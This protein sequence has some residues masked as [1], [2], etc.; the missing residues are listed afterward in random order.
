MNKF[1][2]LI[3]AHG[4]SVSQIENLLHAIFRQDL[5]S[6][7]LNKIFLCSDQTTH[8]NNFKHRCS[9]TTIK[10]E[11]NLGK[12]NALNM[13]LRQANSDIC[14]QNS[15]DCIPSSNWTY[16][17]LL[18]PFLNNPLVGAV[19]CKPEPCDVGFMFLPNIVWKC[20]NYVQPKLCG[21]LFSFKKKLISEL[22]ESVVHDDAYIHHILNAQGYRVVYASEAIVYNSMPKLFSEFYM[23]RKKNVVGNMQLGATFKV[24]PP[25]N[26]RLRSL[27]LMGLEL[28]ANVHGR[29]DYVRGKIPVGLVGYNLKS[30]KE[31]DTNE[32]VVVNSPN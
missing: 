10:Q 28:L 16:H 27:I 23:Q 5:E 26:L 20:H 31:V 17:F 14:V 2:V 13:M 9:I 24:N 25:R 22:P 6:F 3:P 15:A 21:E 12:P 19:T 30:T 4:E 29:L 7:K 11:A 8:I 32:S 1:D 18:K